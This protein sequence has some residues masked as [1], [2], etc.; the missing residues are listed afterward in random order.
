MHNHA[1]RAFT[2]YYGKDVFERQRLEVKAVGGVV[3]GGNGLGIAIDHNR[4]VA[5]FAQGKGGMAAAVVEFNPLPD[6]VGAAAENGNLGP[7]CSLSLVL[8]F[9]GRVKIGG[10]GFKFSGAGID[11]LEN[12]PHAQFMPPFSYRC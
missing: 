4:L 5:I 6:A 1:L 9:I 12:G 3:I 7:V 11:A 8:L 2:F 10:E